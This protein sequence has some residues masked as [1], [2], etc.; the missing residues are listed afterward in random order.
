MV[1]LIVTLLLLVMLPP[2]PFQIK[3]SKL[4]ATI[5]FAV[6][7]ISRGSPTLVFCMGPVGDKVITGGF[8]PMY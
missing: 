5:V 1:V 7:L 8:G 6:Q 2:G 3:V 4:A